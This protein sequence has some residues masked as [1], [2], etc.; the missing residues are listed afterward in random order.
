MGGLE[1]TFLWPIVLG[2][3]WKT[4]NKYGGIASMATGVGS[5][6]VF[7][8]FYPQPFGMH[9]VVTSILISLLGYVLVS[10]VTKGKIKT[11]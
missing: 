2:L 1:A 9:S 8:S 7:E 6:I 10:L 3:Y 11:I 5:Y 4:G